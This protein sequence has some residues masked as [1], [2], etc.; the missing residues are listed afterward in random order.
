MSIRV[1]GV[2]VDNADINAKFAAYEAAGKSI[3]ACFRKNTAM[4]SASAAL[5]QH[6]RKLVKDFKYCSGR[7]VRYIPGTGD[8]QPTCRV[9]LGSESHHMRSETPLGTA[10][11]MPSRRLYRWRGEEEGAPRSATTSTPR[12]DESRGLTRDE[13]RGLTRDESRGLTRDESHGRTNGVKFSNTQLYN[14]F[15]QLLYNVKS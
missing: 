11:K 10:R 1:S 12:R 15:I 2:K 13:S 14:Y 8:S 3:K 7:P 9:S 4:G 5:E 6:E